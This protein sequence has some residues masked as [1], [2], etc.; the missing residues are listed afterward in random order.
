MYL[1]SKMI[2]KKILENDNNIKFSIKIFNNL[3]EG[4]EHL[5]PNLVDLLIL[6]LNL[7]DSSG[8]ETLI[9]AHLKA[10]RV[11]III[12]SGINDQKIMIDTLKIGAHDFIVK[13][14]VD[15]EKILRTILFAIERNKRHKAMLY[16]ESLESNQGYF[17]NII[18]NN[19]DGIVIVDTN[20]IVL[21][22]NN[23]AKKVLNKTDDV[24][25][26]KTFGIKIQEIP[27]TVLKAID[28]AGNENLYEMGIGETILAEEKVHIISLRD[29]TK[30]KKY[31]EKL[32][33][34]TTKDTITKIYN[35]RGFKTMAYQHYKLAKR[36][37]SS[38]LIFFFDIDK[39]K[40]INDKFGHKEGDKVIKYT[41]EILNKTF[42]ES[43]IIAR[44][45]GDEF[46]VLATDSSDKDIETIKN[47]FNNNLKQHIENLNIPFIFSLSIGVSIYDPENPLSINKLLEDAD[48]L[49]YEDKSKKKESHKDSVINGIKYFDDDTG[50]MIS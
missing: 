40:N 1:L 37:K 19:A 14:E 41:A 4:L 48:K 12:L 36:Q 11:P 17:Q 35:I 7:P 38:F 22:L 26:G 6:D 25:V 5:D 31:Q 45:G 24:M 23:F 21:Y 20:N 18:D 47:R 15:N 9:M 46:V 44:W 27:K 10:S 28:N 8:S 16:A 33:D 34:L 43:D 32:K 13:G 49:M 39:I 3:R 42:R 50:Q 29:I 30:H 2:L